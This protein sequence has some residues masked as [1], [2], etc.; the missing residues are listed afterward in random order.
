[1][2]T[3]ARLLTSALA[4]TAAVGLAATGSHATS[5]GR[6]GALAYVGLDHSI[7]SDRLVAG[8]VMTKRL[9]PGVGDHPRWPQDGT[10]LAYAT[11]ARNIVVMKPDGTAKKTVSVGRSW[12]PN[13]MP[14]TG[15]PSQV[16][17]VKVINGKG[18]I[19]AVPA[20]G[21]VAKRLTTDGATTCGNSQPA[22]SAD[23]TYFAYVQRTKQAAGC[24]SHRLVVITRATGV[25]RVVQTVIW[26]DDGVTPLGVGDDRID[27]TADS[28]QIWFSLSGNTDCVETSGVYAVATG[29]VSVISEFDCEG[30]L[31]IPLEEAP[32]PGGGVVT[33]NCDPN[34]SE[35]WITTPRWHKTVPD[36]AGPLWSAFD[37]QP[38]R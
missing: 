23:G 37:M 9:T 30:E 15:K 24:G 1:M 31:G 38:L 17:F 28:A 13:W 32:A 2:N 5:P 36:D 12:Q 21:G 18:D 19:Y 3:P 16:G 20:A 22:W 4:V 25:K 11:G 33:T 27:F 6:P 14:V 34:G 8:Q 10:K 29:R 35:C 26:P 7:Y